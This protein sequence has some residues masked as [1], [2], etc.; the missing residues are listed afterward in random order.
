MSKKSKTKGKRRKGSSGGSL[1]PVDVLISGA[2]GLGAYIG[3]LYVT[4]MLTK[5]KGMKDSGII[6]LAPAL[7]ASAAGTLLLKNKMNAT[8]VA[9][10]AGVAA[11]NVASTVGMI[12]KDPSNPILASLSGD[13]DVI[14]ITPG[15]AR[16]LLETQANQ[17][18]GPQSSDPLGGDYMISGDYMI[19]GGPQS[20]DPLA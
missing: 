13:D 2:M 10:G 9:V 18:Q 3:I 19:N 7:A 6:S 17:L 14:D 12:G 11:Y 16:Q 8:A 20:A 5:E 15:I 1:K 4:R